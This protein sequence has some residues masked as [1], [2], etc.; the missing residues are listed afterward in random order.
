M[1]AVPFNRR[2]RE[3]CS[4]RDSLLCVG[5]DP[6]PERLPSVVRGDVRAFLRAIVSATA[7]YA[8]AFKLNAA[9]YEALG[10]Q[11]WSV[12]QETMTAIPEGV[13]KIYDAKRGDI[14]NS[15]RFYARSSF[16]LLGAD[17]VTVNPYMGYDA[18]APFLEYPGK[19]VFVLCLT[20]NPGA[21][22]LQYLASEQ[23]PL[24][25]RVAQLARAWNRQDNVGLVVGA[26]R[27]EPLRRLRALVPE[28]PFLV[29]GIGA[30]GGEVA[31]VVPAALDADG[32]GALFNA[33]RSILYASSGP[34]FAEAAARAAESL[35]SQ[36]NLHR[37][38]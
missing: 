22:D 14:G 29:P 21:E 36:I 19:G 20:S 5:L 18:V 10:P 34:D 15:S 25:E 6:D 13:L 37:R 31:Q 2:V 12:L 1:T 7:P 27:P 16:A 11:G 23:G 24:Y 35:R 38:R 9:F 28:L 30:Q 17:A 33:S 32:L 26:T 4:A 3:V 8:A